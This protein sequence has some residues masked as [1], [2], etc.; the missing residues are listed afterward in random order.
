MKT[1]WQKSNCQM[2]NRFS[3]YYNWNWFT[4]IAHKKTRN[5][6]VCDLPCGE[7]LQVEYVI[8]DISNVHL[9]SCDALSSKLKVECAFVCILHIMPYTGGLYGLWKSRSFTSA[10]LASNIL[11]PDFFSWGGVECGQKLIDVLRL[12]KLKTV[13]QNRNISKFNCLSTQAE[14]GHDIK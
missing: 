14:D 3:F 6:Y 5:C 7:T 10:S 8:G 9:F 12:S 13:G 4:C 11:P 2:R 1:H